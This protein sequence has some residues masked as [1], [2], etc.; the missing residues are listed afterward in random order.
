MNFLL[1]TC[2]L[3]YKTA[4]VK[5]ESA[6]TLSGKS[7]LMVIFSFS[8]TDLTSMLAGGCTTRGGAA[9]SKNIIC[10]VVVFD[11]VFT[12]GS[13]FSVTVVAIRIVVYSSNALAEIVFAPRF[14]KLISDVQS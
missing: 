11:F 5:K 6:D 12:P 10:A 14:L 8:V 2:T 1:F 9:S 3:L 13:V 7:A 4:T